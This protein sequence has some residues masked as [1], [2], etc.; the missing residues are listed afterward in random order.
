MGNSRR[1][2]GACILIAGLLLVS[3]VVAVI[4]LLPAWLNPA[5]GESAQIRRL[6][7]ASD[8]SLGDILDQRM[9]VV[10]AG[11]VIMWSEQGRPNEHPSRSVY[12]DAYE[13]DRYEVTNVQY[14]R[15]VRNTGARAPRNWSGSGPGTG[16]ADIPVV[17]VS[18][19]EAAGYCAWVGKRL[20]TEAE[21]EKACRGTDGRIYPWGDVWDARLANVGQPLGPARPGT[22]D[23]AWTFLNLTPVSPGSPSLRPIGSFPSGA[24]PFGVMDLVGNAAEWVSDWYNWGDYSGLPDRNP[25]GLGPEW[26]HSLRGSSWYLPYGDAT[27]AQQDSRCSTR[28]ASHAGNSD[29]RLGFRCARSLP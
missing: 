28:D 29:A 18:W 25:Q 27:E 8:P 26:D 12:L 24:S 4:S 19:D 6:A 21:W 3:L 5:K 16:Q 13:I 10:P 9:A 23:E 1:A 2:R 11:T 14:E 17:G 7:A 20:P 15:F 22:W